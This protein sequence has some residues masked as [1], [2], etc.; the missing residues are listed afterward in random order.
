MIA[1][2]TLSASALT[3]ELRK[4]HETGQLKR[5]PFSTDER[6]WDYSPETE[7]EVQEEA[8]CSGCFEM[9]KHIGS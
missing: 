6:D 2:P 1:P 3:T 5:P 7:E 8:L 9:R 4:P